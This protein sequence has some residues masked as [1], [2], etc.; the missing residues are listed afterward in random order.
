LPPEAKAQPPPDLSTA[1]AYGNMPASESLTCG[2]I[3]KDRK[4]LRKDC[5]ERADVIQWKPAPPLLTLAAQM[6]WIVRSQTPRPY[7][8]NQPM[9]C[10]AV[11]A[12]ARATVN[13]QTLFAQNRDTRGGQTLQLCR[14]PGRAGA[15]DEKVRT[16]FL[17]LPQARQTYAVL[18][19]Q[20][21]TSWGYEFGVNE[22]QVAVG[23]L[24][25]RPTLKCNGPGLLGSELAR[26]M[27]ERSRTA[28]QA[29]DLL[30]SLVE[31]YGQGAFA[32]CPADAARDSA[33]LIADPTEAYAVETAGHYWVYQEVQE[34]RAVSNVRVI[35][36]D[37]DRIAQ[38]LASYAI[39]QGWWSNDG[40]KLDFAGALGEDLESQEPAMRRWGRSTLR[41]MEKSGQ[42]DTSFLRRLLSEDS[43]E[44]P[45]R[46]AER[47]PRSALRA[48]QA[49]GM[50]GFVVSLTSDPG[51][52]A[53]AWC[54]FDAPGAGVSF[55]LF[56][57]GELPAAFNQTGQQ[58]GG[59]TIASRLARLSEQLE[60]NP[61]R[62][63]SVR[64]AFAQLQARFDQEAEEWSAEAAA[65][66][67]LG[68]RADLQ[69]QATLFMQHNLESFEEVL[70]DS[71]RTR[72]LVAVDT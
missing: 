45:A 39:S 10:D 16:R 26:L 8:E 44:R 29:V 30:T 35:R 13:G 51:R 66:K 18:G 4:T 33:F 56:L 69:R 28:L 5:G 63:A 68:A 61:G 48:R 47:A 11:V 60:R 54:S 22:H 46:S 34:V 25:L 57:D 3:P 38:G 40:S 58:P 14:T 43:A 42:L 36:Q 67:Q 49:C 27:L 71:M 55:P 23:C 1:A 15:P 62:R 2:T 64:E 9:E 37:W 65:L 12:L 32:G 20:V 19:C 59:E 53:S 72:S 7:Q 41:L 31:R 24:A 6:V 21:E 17:E 70:A 52:L 50:A